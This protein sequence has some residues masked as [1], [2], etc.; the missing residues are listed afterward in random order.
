VARCLAHSAS[1]SH[2]SFRSSDL[3]P[4]AFSVLTFEARSLTGVIFSFCDSSDVSDNDG[5]D[6]VDSDED[7]DLFRWMVD[8]TPADLHLA[9]VPSMA[10]E[11]ELAANVVKAVAST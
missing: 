3:D 5:K 10:T 2:T 6:T 4:T 8:D 7:E 9:V 11:V 1:D